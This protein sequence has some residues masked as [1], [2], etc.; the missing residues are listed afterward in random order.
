[1]TSEREESDTGVIAITD[2]GRSIKAKKVRIF[3][4]G[5]SPFIVV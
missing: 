4:M 5:K 1:V 3:F 2:R